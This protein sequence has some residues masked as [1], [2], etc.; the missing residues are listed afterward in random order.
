MSEPNLSKDPRSD[1]GAP[2][3]ASGPTD[4][5][6]SPYRQGPSAFDEQPA[7]QGQ[8]PSY[9]A[10]RYDQPTYPAGGA[11]YAGIQPTN[12]MAIAS[13][14]AAIAGWTVV[15]VIGWVVAVVLGH[16]ARSQ[17]RTSNQ[18]GAGFALAGLVIGYVS[19]ALV[20]GLVFIVGVL[21]LGL[22]HIA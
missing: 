21:I 19:L 9:D 3:Y 7:P 22:F 14:V 13:L 10:P 11:P 1:A 20:V 5:P 6:F 12:P 4:G 15:P 17:M 16:I 18:Q 2:T 8:S